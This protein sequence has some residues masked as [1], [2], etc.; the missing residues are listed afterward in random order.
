MSAVTF[1]EIAE[2]WVFSTLRLLRHR[3]ERCRVL[4]DTEARRKLCDRMLDRYYEVLTERRH[5][6]E[7]GGMGERTA[8]LV[9]Q[10]N[11]KGRYAGPLIYGHFQ[12][13]ESLSPPDTYYLVDHSLPDLLVRERGPGSEVRRFSTIDEAKEL[14]AQRS[15]LPVEETGQ[16]KKGY[17]IMAKPAVKKTVFLTPVEKAKPAAKVAAPK[18]ATERKPSASVRFREL[19]M[20]GKLTDDAI[21]AA[22]QKEFNLSDDK[23]SYVAWY[24]NDLTKQ[25]K[26]P[27]AP[28][29]GAPPKM[30]QAEKV[31]KMQAGKAAK[32]APP[33]PSAPAAKK[34]KEKAP[35]AAVVAAKEVAAKEVG[36][37]VSTK[38]R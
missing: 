27:P 35:V 37:S 32:K 29:G 5:E 21:F 1:D 3:W 12:V 22:V 9:L 38:K 11:Q 6:L 24:R 7:E 30:T 14:A 26:N 20:E 33:A 4:A 15:Q 18:A 31:A 28:I 25:G 16:P 19:I 10:K 36:K 2:G 17:T 23:R 34:G 8:E 13:M